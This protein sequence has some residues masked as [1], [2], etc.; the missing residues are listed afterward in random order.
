ME[1]FKTVNSLQNRLSKI[2]QNKNLGFVPTMGALHEGHLSIVKKAKTENDYVIASIFV[3]PIQFDK[4][5]DLLKYPKTIK[6]DLEKLASENCD[7]VFIPTVEEIYANIVKSD[8]FDF[9][10]L[11]LVMEGAF[12]K[13]HFDGVGTIV[14]KLFEIIKPNNAYFGE[15]DYQQLQIIKKMVEK[16]QLPVHIVPCKIY[17]EKDGLAMSSRNARLTKKQR[18]EAPL[19]YQTLLKSQSL[20]ADKS[21][22]VIKTMVDNEFRN[23]TILDLEYFEIADIQTL[24]PTN[25]KNTGVKYRAFIA[26]FADSIRLID[27]IALN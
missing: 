10:G 17:R 2:D 22:E 20:F 27:N 24:N 18:N 19:I 4:E 6:K 14:K 26:V 1:V 15:K 23:N 3:N 9:D 16:N 8:S 12:R 25:Q 13:G 5:E 11:D 7:F 21:I